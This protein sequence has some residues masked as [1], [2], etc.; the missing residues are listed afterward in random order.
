[1]KK[2]C[3]HIL[4]DESAILTFEWILLI[5]VLVIGITGGLTAVRDALNWELG[6]VTGAI[7]SLDLSYLIKTPVRL[8]WEVGEFP[9]GDDLYWSGIAAGT[10]YE[11]THPDIYYRPRG[12]ME[13]GG[14]LLKPGENGITSPGVP[15]QEITVN[16]PADTPT[17]TF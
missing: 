17:Y 10:N 2:L 6:G 16:V 1:M 12:G 14:G 8:D 15:H 7:V 13:I 5:T 11:Y 9:P 3:L 4:K